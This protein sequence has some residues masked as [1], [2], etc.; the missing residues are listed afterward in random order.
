MALC[1]DPSSSLHSKDRPCAMATKSTYSSF[2]PD[3]NNHYIC[4]STQRFYLRLI[5]TKRW[6]LYLNL[7]TSI[8]K[9]SNA[10]ASK[11]YI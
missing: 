3:S 1:A 5:N 11:L 8:I 2:T 10:F 4:D 7:I 6:K 9:R